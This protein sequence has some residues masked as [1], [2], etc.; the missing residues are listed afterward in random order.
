MKFFIHC[1]NASYLLVIFL[2]SS[3]EERRRRSLG[4]SSSRSKITNWLSH[5]I[6]QETQI[7]IW[8]SCKLKNSNSIFF[9][10]ATLSSFIVF[11]R[12]ARQNKTSVLVDLSQF[13]LYVTHRILYRITLQIY[14]VQRKRILMKG[15]AKKE[16]TFV[17]YLFHYICILLFISI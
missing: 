3:L 6:T 14:N 8:C 11:S 5:S 7:C 2:S 9:F 10:I 15:N 12:L 17:W 1:A 16:Y 13:F 4:H